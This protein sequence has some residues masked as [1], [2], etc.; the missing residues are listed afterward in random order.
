MITVRDAERD[1]QDIWSRLQH[2]SDSSMTNEPLLR[3]SID[4]SQHSLVDAQLKNL[5]FL[6]RKFQSALTSHATELQLL[7]R[8]IYKNKNQHRGALFWRNVIEIRRC[9]EQV[10]KQKLNESLS[11][12]RNSFFPSTSQGYVLLVNRL[13]HILTAV[14]SVLAI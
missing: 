4:R 6:T 11:A 10:D 7:Q 9:S 5:K 8:L 1:H 3:S 14:L 13:R 2:S 12:L